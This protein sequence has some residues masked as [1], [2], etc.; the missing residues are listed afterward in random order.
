M[1]WNAFHNRGEILRQVIA[2]ADERRDGRLP[3]EVDGV[4]TNFTGELDLLSALMLKWHARLSGNVERELMLEPMDLQHAVARAWRLTSDEMPGVR[5]IIDRYNAQPTDNDMADALAR[6][7]EREWLRLAGA[8]GVASDESNAAARA[9][10][11]IEQDA[12]ALATGSVDP[13]DPAD[14]L[15]EQPSNSATLVERIKA[16][17]AA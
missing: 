6:A 3:V 15:P 11:R 9:G 12:R 16:V 2:V 10:A 8:A 1:T 4:R 13:V 17:L 7:Q 14:M 5:A